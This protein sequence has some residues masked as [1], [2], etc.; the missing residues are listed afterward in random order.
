MLRLKRLRTSIRS[1][2]KLSFLEICLAKNLA[3]ISNQSNELLQVLCC[4]KIFLDKIILF[5]NRLFL[6]ECF[7]GQYKKNIGTTN[8]ELKRLSSQ[9]HSWIWAKL[10]S[11]T[12]VNSLLIDKNVSCLAMETHSIHTLRYYFLEKSSYCTLEYGKCSF[13]QTDAWF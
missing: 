2:K 1:F 8:L 7:R 6:L 13:S 5:L 4:R 11:F 9:Y 12:D 3:T 10:F